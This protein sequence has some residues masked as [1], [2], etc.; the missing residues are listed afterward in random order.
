MS[1][2]KRT[3]IGIVLVAV[4]GFSLS[5]VAGRLYD[6][7]GPESPKVMQSDD[8]IFSAW[9]EVLKGWRFVLVSCIQGEDPCGLTN[10]S[11]MRTSGRDAPT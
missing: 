10:T 9:D 1:W 2:I 8:S 4:V 7:Y 6:A 3:V 5:A 11:L